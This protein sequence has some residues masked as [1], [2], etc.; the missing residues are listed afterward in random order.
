MTTLDRRGCR[1]PLHTAVLDHDHDLDLDVDSPVD[2]AYG[3]R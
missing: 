1:P 3:V 2:P